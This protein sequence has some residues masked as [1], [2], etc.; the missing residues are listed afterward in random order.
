MTNVKT[1]TRNDPSIAPAAWG[2]PVALDIALYQQGLFRSDAGFNPGEEVMVAPVGEISAGDL[3]QTCAA[4]ALQRAIL[5]LASCDVRSC[6]ADRLT[7]ALELIPTLNDTHHD[8]LAAECS[9]ALSA[10]C[11]AQPPHQV[12]RYR[13]GFVKQTLLA[14]LTILEDISY[15]QIGVANDLGDLSD[16]LPSLAPHIGIEPVLARGAGDVKSEI[17]VKLRNPLAWYRRNP[18][19]DEKRLERYLAAYGQTPLSFV[20]AVEATAVAA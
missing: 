20:E 18:A 2:D 12:H 6:S 3:E 9:K 1:I 19:A 7:R 11:D 15:E 14:V 13:E 5:T 17:P 8:L 4:L 10:G 16:T